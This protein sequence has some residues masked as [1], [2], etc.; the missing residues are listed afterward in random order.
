[1]RLTR[2]TA[3]RVV[4]N[5]RVDIALAAGA[6]GVHLRGDSIAPETVRRITPARFLI[7]RSVHG[8]EEAAGVTGADY[9]IAGTVWPSASKPDDHHRLGLNGLAAVVEAVDV[10]VLAIGG[11]ALDR[12]HDVSL[13]GAAGIAAIGLFMGDADHDCRAVPL[14]AIVN[15]LRAQ[16][17]TSGSRS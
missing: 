6:D 14:D 16:F 4:V 9:L 11:V 17:D 12:I 10:P 8:A 5:D 13:A 1:V 3:T 15:E 2:G 7:G